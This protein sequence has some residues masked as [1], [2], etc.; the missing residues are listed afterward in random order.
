MMLEEIYEIHKDEI[1]KRLL[2]FKKVWLST[3]EDI[4]TEMAFCMFTPQTKAHA[5]WRAA[6][7]LRKGSLLFKGEA[8]EI[9]QIL[10]SSGVR[11]HKNKTRYLLENRDKFYPKT[12]IKIE[13]YLSEDILTAREGLKK[14]VKGWGWKEASHFLRNIGFGQDIAILDRHILRTL[15]SLGVIEDI[16]H[17]LNKEYLAIEEKMID[18]CNKVGISAAAMDMVMW[19]NVNGEFFK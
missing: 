13:E 10:S 17:N 1:E 8:G 15:L 4:F 11:F 6:T 7:A 5:G 12:K 9:G 19:Y 14:D 16:S 2:D 3:D 18:Y